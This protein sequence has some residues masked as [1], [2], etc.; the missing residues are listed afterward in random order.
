MIDVF[1]RPFRVEVLVQMTI[2]KFDHKR[3]RIT[4]AHIIGGN[5]ELQVILLFPQM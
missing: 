1:T 5:G 3:G 4:I 2:I